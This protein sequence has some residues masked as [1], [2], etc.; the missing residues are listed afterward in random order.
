M[1]DSDVIKTI[2]LTFPIPYKIK[3]VDGLQKELMLSDVQISRLKGK[4]L[5]YIPPSIF[6]AIGKPGGGKKIKLK[7]IPKEFIPLIAAVTEL[8]P[9]SVGEM[10]IDD[11]IKIAEELA[12][13]MMGE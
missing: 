11:I 5:D 2:K 9:E 4:H 1:R 10:V 12:N 6:N 13:T 7:I 3:D 8:T